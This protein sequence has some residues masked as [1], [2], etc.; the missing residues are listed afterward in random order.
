MYGQGG[1][2]FLQN[3]TSFPAFISGG[4][5]NDIVIGGTGMD[6]LDGG[7]GDDQVQGDEGN[8][9]IIGGSGKDLLTGGQGHDAF[10]SDEFDKQIEDRENFVYTN[11]AGGMEKVWEP[12]MALKNTTQPTTHGG[13]FV[14]GAASWSERERDTVNEAVW[15]LFY[16]GWGNAFLR[17]RFNDGRIDMMREGSLQ[18]ETGNVNTKITAYNSYGVLSFNNNTFAPTSE[19]DR[20]IWHE[21][22]HN[23]D[24]GTDQQILFNH[25]V[26]NREFYDGFNAIAGW[27]SVSDQELPGEEWNEDHSYRY[28]NRDND[29]DGFLT[30][31]GKSNPKEDWATTFDATVGIYWNLN[32]I[33]DRDAGRIETPQQV[34][35]RCKDRIDY[36]NSF[37][38]KIRQTM[39]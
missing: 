19:P 7:P 24:D 29:L 9:L 32:L 13:G 35:V 25:A 15:K 18:D 4:D 31:H 14:G 33:I 21:F 5:G 16:F 28:R 20:I 2:D 26:S 39:Q 23:W 6:R 8:D 30:K 27:K 34:R 3:R 38:D 11:S 10:I 22:S 1:G 37:V 17:T 12:V 36:M